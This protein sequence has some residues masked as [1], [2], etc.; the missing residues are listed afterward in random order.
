[1]LYKYDKI[2]QNH[3]GQF[4][5]LRTIFKNRGNFMQNL[6]TNIDQYATTLRYDLR[7]IAFHYSYIFLLYT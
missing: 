4:D 2:D 3:V 5:H 1:M 6:L 7:L